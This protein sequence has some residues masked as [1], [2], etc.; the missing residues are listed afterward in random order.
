MRERPEQILKFVCWG[1]AVLVL[2]Q[3]IRIVFA[4][5]PLAHVA[6][7]ALPSL[8]QGSS[9]A[10]LG[11]NASPSVV[12]SDKA[13]RNLKSAAKTNL[14]LIATNA[15]KPSGAVLKETNSNMGPQLAHAGTNAVE[16]RAATG[17]NSRSIHPNNQPAARLADASHLLA[18]TKK[19][20]LPPVIQAGIDRITESEILGPVI[21]PLPMALLG[22]AGDVA[23]LRAPDGQTGL[24]KQG[25]DLGG[26]KLL[27]IGTN[28]VLI[29][30]A[31]QQ[32]ELTIFAGIGG[33]PLLD[34]PPE[35][36][37]ETN[38]H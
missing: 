38:T 26:I 24:V 8:A 17:T 21:R 16:T 32:M 18:G 10:G 20:T 29:D 34:N 36:A 2:F 1:L 33:Q 35:T 9:T 4:A 27:R 25:D 19:A 15:V 31:G 23:F 28:R 3:V 14:T 12:S 11:T 30:Q 37:H 22:I 5:N 6:I 7:P 13:G